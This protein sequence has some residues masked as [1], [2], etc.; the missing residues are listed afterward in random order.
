MVVLGLVNVN[1]SFAVPQVPTLSGPARTVVSKSNL[2]MIKLYSPVG[3]K[4]NNSLYMQ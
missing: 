4:F 3:I 2:E 1:S